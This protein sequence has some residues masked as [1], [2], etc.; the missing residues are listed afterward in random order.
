MTFK[1]AE[2]RA[3]VQALLAAGLCSEQV[4]KILSISKDGAPRAGLGDG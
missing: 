3:R 2:L 1:T 4:A